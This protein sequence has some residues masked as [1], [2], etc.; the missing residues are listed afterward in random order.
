M[1]YNCVFWPVF[2]L[3]GQKNAHKSLIYLLRPIFCLFAIFALFRTFF[4]FLFYMA[5]DKR[6]GGS[7]FLGWKRGSTPFNS[8]PLRTMPPMRKLCSN[9]V[10]SY[11][12]TNNHSFTRTAASNSSLEAQP[13]F[14]YFRRYVH[15]K[16][17]PQSGSMYSFPTL[18]TS[19]SGLVLS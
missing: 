7:L 2:G 11:A 19:I 18:K 9:F 5:L 15:T 14:V 3:V 16:T 8:D 17:A 6:V 4:I 1:I 10:P 13:H 12:S